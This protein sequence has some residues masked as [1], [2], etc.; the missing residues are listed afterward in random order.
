[1]LKE[2][3]NTG[4]RRERKPWV[5]F[6]QKVSKL[7]IWCEYSDLKTKG[8]FFAFKTPFVG[9]LL[10]GVLVL[11]VGLVFFCFVFLMD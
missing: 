7:G 10:C 4:E 11:V 8:T 5:H 3:A 2:E 1:M 6:K 9:L